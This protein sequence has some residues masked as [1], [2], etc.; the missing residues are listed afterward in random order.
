MAGD[1]LI[2]IQPIE[3]DPSLNKPVRAASAV[4]AGKA[5][6]VGLDVGSTT[7]KYSI[8]APSGELL[9]QAYE[10]HNTKQAEKV[11]D[12]LTRLEKDHG[13]TPEV[14]RVFFTGSGAGLIA[15]LVGGKVIQ[16]VVAVAAAVEKVHPNV[17]FVS[18]IGGEDMKTIFFAGD[19]PSKSKQVLMQSACSG[20]TGTFIEKTA[21]KLEIPVE[22]LSKMGYSG[23]TLHKISSKCGIFAEADSNT[24]LKA[25]VSVEEI[26]ASLFEAVVYQN[27]ATLTRGNTPLPEILLLGGPNLFFK[28]LQEAW[29]YHL[30][31][32]WK[33]RKVAIPDDRDP[34]S[35]IKVP[36]D[37]LYYA[38]QGCIEVG[39]SDS[40]TIGTYLGTAK[41]KWWI[42]E[43]QH[44]EKKK[45]GSAGLWKDPAELQSFRDR[46]SKAGGNGNGATKTEKSNGHGKGNGKGHAN[47]DAIRRR[48]RVQLP[49]F[50][51]TS[52]LGPVVVGCDF[53]ST[54]AKAVCMSPDKDLL[55]SCYALSRGNPIDDAKSLFRQVREAVGDGE[56]LGLAITGYGKDLL[57]DI[58]GAD[59]PVVETIAHASAGLH[60]FPDADCICDVG[61]VDVKIMLLNNGAVT[62]F[63]L[64][65]QCSSGNGAF[66]QGVAER[67]NIPMS[68]MADGAFRAQSMPQLSMGCG[69][70]L[71]S[72]IVNQQRKGW[73]AEEILAG[74]CAIL[75]LNVWIY[76]GGLN[77]LTSV[78]KKYILQGGTH[79]NLA[80]V[81]TQVDFILKKVPDAEVVVHPYSGEA[82]AIGAALVAL[83]WWDG[84]GE[85]KF[86]GFDAIERLTYKTA[87]SVD[88]VCH[89]CP[90]TC[91]RSFIDVELDG[92][93]GRE[94]S[95][96]PLE[97]GWERVIVNNSCPKGLVEDLNEMKVIKM[98]MEKTKNAFPNVADLVRK[99]AFRRVGA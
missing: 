83:D 14:D 62:D 86:R 68:E 47:G 51:K 87:T 11:L 88:T 2:Q 77:N 85:S 96:V 55:F 4:P 27:L 58:L 45:L 5:K 23:Y 12:F 94:W 33:E 3:A 90:V 30:A 74:L 25:G 73:Q 34:A 95:K 15:P 56:I 80:V 79:K 43:G 66:L 7:C 20:G 1:G 57:K 44:E 29:R 70:F 31:K 67:F 92:G 89:W 32:L 65:S 54:T 97:K 22:Q 41:L 26:I 72:D 9:G 84:G 28:G 13:L 40:P 98:G 36:D 52:K 19:G 60:Y 81:K 42:D 75:P 18:E 10:R 99:E 93:K 82:G 17:R 71:Q 63:R 16:E 61:G 59:C 21:R 49:I 8:A 76:A 69:V 78:G 46:Y 50:G 37:A 91:Q 39:K 48:P 38:A 64:N 24:L 53:G 35:F 6:I